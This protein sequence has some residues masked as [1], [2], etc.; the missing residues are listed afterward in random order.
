MGG[1]KIGGGNGGMFSGKTGGDMPGP[2]VS[3]KGRQDIGPNGARNNGSQGGG[4]IG[5]KALDYGSNMLSQTTG[6]SDGLSFGTQPGSNLFSAKSSKGSEGSQGA[7]GQADNNVMSNITQLLNAIVQLLKGQ[8]QGGEK[9]GNGE[10]NAPTEGSKTEGSNGTQG[11]GDIMTQLMEMI[12]KMLGQE[13]EGSKTGEATSEQQPS[14]ESTQNA[15]GGDTLTQLMDMIKKLL[16]QS[17]EGGES[18]GKSGGE[19]ST[20]AAAQNTNDNQEG[21]VTGKLGTAL[22]ML[23]LGTLLS[24]LQGGAGGAQGGESTK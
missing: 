8:S 12:K 21:G 15:S 11:S 14:S 7:D 23:G 22:Q 6:K 19:G 13:G 20:P 4:S 1:M 18:T 10:S 9:A 17:T 2:D 5:G 24:A 16:G 3:G